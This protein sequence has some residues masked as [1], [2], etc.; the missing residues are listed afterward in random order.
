MLQAKGEEQWLCGTQAI[1]SYVEQHNPEAPD[2]GRCA[3]WT[4]AMLS[5]STRAAGWWGQQA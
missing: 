3:G 4:S 1:W 2:L 5:A